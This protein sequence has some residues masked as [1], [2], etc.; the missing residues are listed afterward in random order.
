MA[1]RHT[2]GTAGSRG[3]SRIPVLARGTSIIGRER[4]LA[5]LTER[6]EA[7]GR[8]EACVVV[9][10]GEPG[11]GKSRILREFAERALGDGWIVLSGSAY[12]TEGMPPYLPFVEV[13]RQHVHASSDEALQPLVA[14]APEVATLLP[15]V[16]ARF[17]ASPPARRSP[18][19]ER[20]ALFQAVS[21][22]LV[23]A[24]DSTESRGLLIC[25]D[26][27]HW[28]DR[29]TLLLFQHL[30]RTIS[31]ARICLAGTHRTVGVD[32]A[33]PLSPILADLA[34]EHLY[35]GIP[36]ESL[37]MEETAILAAALAGREAIPRAL[38]EALHGR[39]RGNPFF[40]EEFVHHL[41]TEGRDLD[42]PAV[43]SAGWG[44]PEGV[45]QVIGNR[46]GRLRPEDREFLRAA[47]VL[48]DDFG[49][50]FPTIS[51][52][53]DVGVSILAE[54]VEEAV[55]AGLLR[56]DGETYRFGH[57]LIRD[58]LLDDLPLS[59]RQRL[60]LSAASAIGEVYAPSLDPWLSAIAFHYRL[61]GPFT[62]GEKAIAFAVRA[63]EAAERALSYDEAMGHWDAALR[64][65]SSHGAARDHQLAI[66]DRLGE[67]AQVSGFDAY[68]RSIRYFEQALALHEAAGDRAGA[69]AMHARIALVLAAA[70][71][72]NDNQAAAHHLDTAAPVL[73]SG[74][75]GRA[76][77][78]YYSA[79]G[80]LAVWQENPRQGL[81]ASRIGMELATELGEDDRWVS[82][83]VMHS[84]HL[85]KLGNVGESIE[86]NSRA[87]EAA[88]RLNNPFRSYTAASFQATRL[89]KMLAPLEALPWVQR[90]AE[91]PRQLHAPTRRTALFGNVADAHALA[92]NLDAAR[93]VASTTGARGGPYLALYEGNWDRLEAGMLGKLQVAR[94]K[95]AIQDQGQLLEWLAAVREARGDRA[96]A[97]EALTE[98]V[99]IGRAAPN[100]LVLM[101]EGPALAILLALCGREAE[102]GSHLERC[103]EILAAG[104]DWRGLAGR[105]ALAQAT[106]AGLGGC[107]EEAAFSL[108]HAIE[109]FQSH[110][111]PWAEAEALL[112]WG[113]ILA[114]AGRQ[115]RHEASQS[116]AA[117]LAI[118]TGRGAGKPWL[119]RVHALQQA[120][121]GDKPTTYPDG[122][123]EREVEVLRLVASGR[124]SREIGETLVLSVR[125]VERHIA[126]VYIKTNTHGR[127][128]ATAYALARGLGVAGL[129]ER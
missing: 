37:S 67:V 99:A 109:T 45:R 80:L 110:A 103:T 91:T 5:A 125:T 70:S 24:A 31:A 73:E 33:H 96:G 56:E 120:A 9:L 36:L 84:A 93:E 79:L 8:G 74:P 1:T 38:A 46:I 11:I 90:E 49:Q 71:G 19:S 4:E 35:E 21:D 88:D 39:A 68:A 26:D 95:A 126:N 129:L 23:H 65:M 111:L 86:L 63:G 12:D 127:A 10:S 32:A 29:S 42:D 97:I 117:A 6:L 121:L 60:H 18:E 82:N 114:R 17:G 89:L 28:A 81:E 104:E 72:V 2:A 87:W 20:Y 106:V 53:L 62:D 123:T 58:A 51:R 66:L 94:E 116:F 124:S 34:R 7:A 92:G 22:F 76:Q 100:A 40:I 3:G 118:Y 98:A 113:Q 108:A 50:M 75:P 78:S 57:A 43:A 41:Q 128:Q 55:N 107:I 105:V 83:A 54:T 64:L 61:A 119:E 25:L 15:E 102:A 44:I 48:G 16:V 112:L 47:A 85:T 77:L 69:A 27:L 59:R 14:A 52:M 30:A 115:H 101:S 13:L 122:L